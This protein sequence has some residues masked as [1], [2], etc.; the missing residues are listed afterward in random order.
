MFWGL[1]HLAGG[2]IEPYDPVV[3]AVPAPGRTAM[4][5]LSEPR[6]LAGVPAPSDADADLAR[7]LDRVCRDLAGV[8]RE[9]GISVAQALPELDHAWAR[10]SLLA[11]GFVHVGDLA[12]LAC[13][14][15]PSGWAAPAQPLPEGLRVRTA[16]AIAREQSPTEA[17][18]R[19]IEA[20][21]ASYVGTLDCP[22]LCGL[23]DS[24]DILDSHR[25]TGE[26]DP[27]LW[28]LVERDDGATAVCLFSLSNEGRDGELV[29]LGLSPELRGQGLGGWLLDQG[30]ADIASRGCRRALCAV[31][32]RNAPALSI[33]GKRGFHETSRRGAFVRRI[34]P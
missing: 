2:S 16:E 6:Q 3:L 15:P 27:S 19:L 17:D 30:L 18:R 29:Y 13:A 31:D 25:A 5:F 8:E 4:L 10:A 26:H 14:S 9:G 28:R 12:Y 21:D 34:T 11:A 24:A 22:E 20:L 23:R 7:T 33:Y 32:L 1:P